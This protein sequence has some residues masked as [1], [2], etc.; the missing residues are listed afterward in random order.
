[1]AGYEDYLR[2]IDEYDMEIKR[3]R[4]ENSER[5]F[6]TGDE[7]FDEINPSK[8]LREYYESEAE[9]FRVYV[10]VE[11][12]EGSVASGILRLRFYLEGAQENIP[13]LKGS[14]AIY[15]SRIGI[16]KVKREQRLGSMLREFFFYICRSEVGKLK[17]PVWVYLKT[18]DRPEMM[19]FFESMRM[20]VV[21]TYS[22]PSGGNQL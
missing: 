3:I 6:E 14:P 10:L 20:R 8:T 11:A 1:M 4:K 21:S 22:D 12:K 13:G 19:S 2:G 5:S 9:G 7:V 15:L 18:R 16:H 17:K